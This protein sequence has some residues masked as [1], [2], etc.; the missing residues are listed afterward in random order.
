MICLLLVERGSNHSHDYDVGIQYDTHF[1]CFFIFAMIFKFL[2]RYYEKVEWR[3]TKIFSKISLKI[4]SFRFLLSRLQQLKVHLLYIRMQ[5][6]APTVT[7]SWEC[8]VIIW[9]QLQRVFNTLM[10]TAGHNCLQV[11]KEETA[12]KWNYILLVVFAR[13][14]PLSPCN[15]LSVRIM[16]RLWVIEWCYMITYN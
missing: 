14:L 4:P 12:C 5:F 7:C 10:P 16:Y 8:S 13:V 15:R 2:L 9:A 1:N 11:Y 3:P 6:K